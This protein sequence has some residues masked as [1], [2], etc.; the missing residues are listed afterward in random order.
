MCVCIHIQ[1]IHT[2]THAHIDNM[3]FLVLDVNQNL[4][5]LAMHL[6]GR[7]GTNVSPVLAMC[8]QSRGGGAMMPSL[9]LFRIYHV[10][11]S[12][13]LSVIGE[14]KRLEV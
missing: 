12:K 4:D 10:K 3:G 2:H 14:T 5:V 8:Q 9:E 7:A 11:D 6:A 13:G 1:Y